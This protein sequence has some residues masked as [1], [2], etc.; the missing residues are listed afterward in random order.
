MAYLSSAAGSQRLGENVLMTHCTIGG[1]GASTKR[2]NKSINFTYLWGPG[3]CD[4]RNRGPKD[5]ID[6][7]ISEFASKDHYKGDTI[8][9][10]L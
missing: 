7:G 6:I 9:H 4:G 1:F 10:G 8:N 3:M 2:A 5:H